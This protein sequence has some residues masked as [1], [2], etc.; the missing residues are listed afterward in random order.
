MTYKEYRPIDEKT[1]SPTC[2]PEAMTYLASQDIYEV[3]YSL[4]AV[5]KGDDKIKELLE[6]M[7]FLMTNDKQSELSSILR[8]VYEKLGPTENVLNWLKELGP[9]SPSFLQWLFEETVPQQEQFKNLT[10]DGFK[11]VQSMF[12]D[13][14]EHLKKLSH[15]KGKLTIEPKPGDANKDTIEIEYTNKK[16][17]VYVL[18]DP[19]RLSGLQ[20]LEF[21]LEFV[22]SQMVYGKII[23][24]I[25][26]LMVSLDDS[27]LDRAKEIRSSIISMIIE[28]IRQVNTEPELNDKLK[29][30]LLRNLNLLSQLM[31]ETEINGLFDLQPHF[32]VSD[33]AE[34]ITIKFENG[35]I[36]SK[37]AK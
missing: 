27:L 29:Q 28:H 22:S 30:K 3:L 7:R 25:I 6:F 14:N 23:E 33:F 9:R 36:N 11:A 12:V 13:L 20:F 10:L 26:T 8:R 5:Q 32:E 4:I 24:F 35:V 18:V 31:V 21:L 2:L 15:Y 34:L 17:F 16:D 37:V 1:A 19:T